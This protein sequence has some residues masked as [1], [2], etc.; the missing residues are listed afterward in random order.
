MIT[1]AAFKEEFKKL[2]TR[3]QQLREDKGFS[4]SELSEK[5]GIR[6]VYL[7]KIEKGNAYGMTFEKHLIK[8]ADALEIELSK[9]FENKEL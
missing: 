2:G 1:K 5:T 3:I 8:I 6:K 9:I 4:I 7:Q